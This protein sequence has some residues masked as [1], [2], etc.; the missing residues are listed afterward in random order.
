MACHYHHG[1]VAGEQ[2]TVV[3]GLR[4]CHPFSV[5]KQRERRIFAGRG[6]CLQ[7]QVEITKCAAFGWFSALAYVPVFV[8]NSKFL[9]FI[10]VREGEHLC[11]AYQP[12]SKY[13]SPHTRWGMT[14]VLSLLAAD[15]ARLKAHLPQCLGEL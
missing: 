14:C 2:D 8:E 6:G 1:R 7:N 5:G 3:V 15:G 4:G 13:H 10:E 11:M 12:S 9:L